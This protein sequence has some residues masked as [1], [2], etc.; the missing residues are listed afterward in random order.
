M[1]KKQFF[2][3]TFLS[4]MIEII[5]SPLRGHV[6]SMACAVVTF[7]LYFI[8]T[9]LMLKNYTSKLKSKR[10]LLA[11]LVGCLIIQL[12]FRVIAFRGTLI[13]F[14]DFLFHLFGIFMGYFFYFSGKYIKSGIV[15][16]SIFCC[17]FLYFKGYDLWI[18]KLN[19]GTFS[20]II[21][22]KEQTPEFQFTSMDGNSI[23][24]TDFAEKYVILDF[25]NSSCGVCFREFPK[26]EDQ[27]VKYQSKNNIALYSVNVLLKH[28]AQGSIDPFKIISEKGYTFPT[29]QG[30]RV[31]DAKNIFGVDVYPTVIVLNPIGVMV[32]RGNVE[33]AFSFVEDELKRNIL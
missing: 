3:I 22:D 30:G 20:G 25:W 11:C 1:N 16:I 24:N 8:F 31:E 29:L 17:T 5:T 21:Q 23:T 12:P 15:V 19:F 2:Y 10:I 27:Y 13:S 6:S 7:T 4:L 18:H 32:Y 26:F 14:P 28:E 9:N 33:G